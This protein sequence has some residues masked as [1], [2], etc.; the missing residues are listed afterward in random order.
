MRVQLKKICVSESGKQTCRNQG[1]TICNKC[2]IKSGQRFHGHGTK[3]VLFKGQPIS[4][5]LKKL[6]YGDAGSESTGHPKKSG[7]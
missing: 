7:D 1:T 4:A 5:L 3:S 2:G 6:L